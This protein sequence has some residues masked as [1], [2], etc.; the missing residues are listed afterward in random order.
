MPPPITSAERRDM[1]LLPPGAFR[2]AGVDGSARKENPATVAVATSWPG[3]A[4]G[5]VRIAS[6]A[7]DGV[8][9]PPR[10]GSSSLGSAVAGLG[11]VPLPRRSRAAHDSRVVV[12]L[13]RGEVRKRAAAQL[14][15][16]AAQPGELRVLH[17]EPVLVLHE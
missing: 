12:L 5:R 8:A 1:M 15:E 11:R 2:R 6:E 4:S 17:R 3:C 7:R 10:A 9:A 14:V 16:Q 13:P